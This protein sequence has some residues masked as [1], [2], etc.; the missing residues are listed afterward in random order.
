MLSRRTRFHL[1]L[2]ALVVALHL[3]FIQAPGPVLALADARPL[4]LPAGLD[5]LDL[6]PLADGRHAL[7]RVRLAGADALWLVEWARVDELLAGRA[8]LP[9][10]RLAEAPGTW[11]LG[12]VRASTGAFTWI[13][14]RP[15]QGGRVA[16]RWAPPEPP[17]TRPLPADAL[18][19]RDDGDPVR[20]ADL[21]AQLVAA[22]TPHLRV[23]PRPAA[24][25]GDLAFVR[26]D[27][28]DDLLVVD[29]ERGTILRAVDTFDLGLAWIAPRGGRL[30]FTH[31]THT[32]LDR[33]ECEGTTCEEHRGPEA[34]T[35]GPAITAIDERP[36]P[37][38]L[39]ACTAQGD[40]LLFALGPA[41]RFLAAAPLPGC[42]APL[43]VDPT[44]VLAASDA[45]WQVLRFTP[46]GGY[47]R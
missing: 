19:L 22:G 2:A 1:L 37:A 39:A 6:R 25:A 14:E 10:L 17:Q 8:A 32:R 45:G 13:E 46:R 23:D 30:H 26:L 33:L 18:W 4:P 38:R 11:S 43:L 16:V 29:R 34:S 9:D 28:P 24:L 27:R 42:R 41:D 31:G 35:R 44:T 40:L 3:A 15:A 47:L 36:D 20:A 12:H 21:D 5:L 7:A